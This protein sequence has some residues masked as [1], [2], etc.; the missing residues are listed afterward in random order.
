MR[1]ASALAAILAAFAVACSG[2]SGPKTPTP[3]SSTA[4][5]TATSAAR[6]QASATAPAAEPTIDPS[7][8]STNPITIAGSTTASTLRDV[9]IGLHPELGGWDRIVFQ[10]DG[11]L[12]NVDVRY[13]DSASQCASGMPVAVQGQAI[14]GVRLSPTNAHTEQGQATLPSNAVPGQGGVITETKGYCDFEAV[15]QWAIGVKAKQPFKVT[16]LTNPTRLVIDIKQ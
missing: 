10:F 12:P 6:P 4:A 8:A 3:T 11:P 13:V 5:A 1:L 9:R 7:S 16:T 2:D 15:V 14:V